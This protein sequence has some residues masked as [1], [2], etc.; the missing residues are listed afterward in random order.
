MLAGLTATQSAE[1]QTVSLKYMGITILAKVHQRGSETQAN[2][3]R[4]ALHAAFNFGTK[5]DYDHTRMGEKRFHLNQNPVSLTKKNTAA[6]RSTV[7]VL[8]HE[9]LYELWHNL[10]EAPWVGLIGVQMIRF[11]IATA[12][13]RPKQR[14][15]AKWQDY[16]LHRRCVTIM[17]HKRNGK[18]LP[19]VVPLTPKA[20]SILEEVRTYTSGYPWPFTVSHEAHLNPN[21]LTKILARWYEYRLQQHQNSPTAFTKPDRFRTPPCSRRSLI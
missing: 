19:H 5:S 8:T 14:L 10:P 1:I 13:Q 9:E 3:T 7:R 6:E 20:I 21:S 4:A 12:G 11:L 15:T 16:D 17:N 18:S 2:M